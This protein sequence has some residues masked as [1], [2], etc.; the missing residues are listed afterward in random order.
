[1]VHIRSCLIATAL[2]LAMAATA[3]AQTPPAPS[4]SHLQAAREVA[5]GS[6]ITRSFDSLLPVFGEQIK[7]N[8][9][10]RP[11]IQ[12]DLTDVLTKLEPEMEQQK[13]E[14]INA[15]ARIFAAR[16]AEAE[17]KEVAAF[18]K[19]PAGKRYVDIQPLMLDELVRE[20]QLWTARVSEFV[21]T[22]VRNEMGKRGHQLQ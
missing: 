10:T 13:Q 1:M 14:L 18:F 17:L 9:L 2:L 6:G 12:K 19:S 5:I 8:T 20:V 4:P 22:R 21:M 16:M 15:A 7:Q 3:P 11:E